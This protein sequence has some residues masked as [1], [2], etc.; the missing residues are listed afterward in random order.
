M[1]I[2]Y[3]SA[4]ILLACLTSCINKDPS[5]SLRYSYSESDKVGVQNIKFEDLRGMKSGEA[6]SY[7]MLYVLPIG[8][9]SI[10][11]AANNGTVNSVVYIAKSG[12]WTFP[13]SKDCTVVYG[14]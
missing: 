1:K 7:K 14:S 8:D 3:I 5:R 10:M 6:C 9:N 4:L 2:K 11:T 13:F 12:F